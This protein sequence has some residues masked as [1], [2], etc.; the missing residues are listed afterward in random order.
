MRSHAALVDAAAPPA[1]PPK[2]RGIEDLRRLN[3]R[4]TQEGMYAGVLGGGVLSKSADAVRCRRMAV[5]RRHGV[6][7]GGLAATMAGKTRLTPAFIA[8]RAGVSK[9]GLVLSFIREC[10]VSSSYRR[11]PP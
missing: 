7:A 11:R 8:H 3:R 9:N 6:G 2:I 10:A 1:P 4:A 5:G